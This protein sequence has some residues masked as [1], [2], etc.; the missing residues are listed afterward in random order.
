M[1]YGKYTFL[2]KFLS[3]A[4][5][6]Y[7]KGSTFRGVFGIAL[8]KI[9]CTLK[10]NECNSCLL[11][12]HC[13][14][15]LVFETD[16]VIAAAKRSKF[17]AVP[18]PFVIEPPLEGKSLFKAGDSFEF[19]MLL[20][21]KINTKIPYFIYA[22]NEMGN[23]GLGKKT[24]GKRGKFELITVTNASKMIYRA[25]EQ[26]IYTQAVDRLNLDD[27]NKFVNKD[28]GESR[29]EIILETPLRLKFKNRLN[30][31]L[32]FHILVRA[33]LRRVSSLLEN[34]GHG[35]PDIDYKGL[36]KHADKITIS[37]NNLKWFDWK[38]YSS[39]Q[40]AKMLMGGIT[41]SITYK[42]RFDKYLP[43]LNFC[44]KIHIGKQTAFGLGKFRFEVV[45]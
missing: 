41:G 34:Y 38:R 37:H 24:D 8:K 42:G 2:C 15:A 18:H 40:N 25:S 17:A 27:S 39:R 26:K 12:T 30:A 4:E 44:S 28:Q 19:N 31:D 29:L 36:V 43:L 45:K 9:A 1:N 20:F 6:P 11:N 35:E 33:M 32:P 5:L 22:L 7:Y 14:Y 16:K 23:I 10:N 13:I 21:G 3:S